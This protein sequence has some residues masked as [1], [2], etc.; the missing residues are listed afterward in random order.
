MKNCLL[1]SLVACVIFVPWLYYVIPSWFASG[2]VWSSVSVEWN[3][4][5]N[6]WIG[7]LSRLFFLDENI[8]SS[9]FFYHLS[10]ILSVGITIYSFYLLVK[11][12]SSSRWLMPVLITLSTFLPLAIMD[13]VLGG[14]RSTAARY[15]MPTFLG[16]QITVAFA[17]GS[18]CLT[19]K[20]T[21]RKINQFLLGVFLTIGTVSCYF[22]FQSTTAWTKIVSYNLNEVA[23]KV[24][25]QEKPLIISNS[26]NEN[27]GNILALSYLLD[28]DT[29]FILVD[30]WQKPDS[31]TEIEIPSKFDNIYLLGLSE[32]AR[33]K[34]EQK[35]SKQSES[36]F[37]DNHIHLWKLF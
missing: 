7:H 34:L 35:Y 23:S 26:D 8:F 16:I 29:S 17:L 27:F 4:L 24:N 36:I 32:L 12:I 9:S 28:R 15:L 22:N 37:Q 30:G 3:T 31:E 20:Q 13:L 10:L 11:K 18:G 19:K 14:Q 21:Y 33:K 5:F 1:A 25:Q 6:T 2:N